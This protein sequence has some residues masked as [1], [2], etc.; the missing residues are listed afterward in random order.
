VAPQ[1]RHLATGDTISQGLLRRAPDAGPRHRGARQGDEQRFG[2][3]GWSK[4]RAGCGRS[5]IAMR[6]IWREWNEGRAPGFPGG[7]SSNDTQPHDH[8]L[9]SGDQGGESKGFMASRTERRD[10]Q[11][12][13]QSG[14]RR[15]LVVGPSEQAILGRSSVTAMERGHA[16]T[17]EP[18]RV[19]GSRALS[20]ETGSRAA[21]ARRTPFGN[22]KR[23]LDDRLR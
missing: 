21:A 15:M 1:S 13:R 11:R 9:R 4:R 17:H 14:G 16:R 6:A 5:G 22:G 2:V 12:C 7:G 10:G 23:F 3:V 18:G 8:G 19:R 20:A